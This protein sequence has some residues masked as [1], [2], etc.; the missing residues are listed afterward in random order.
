MLGPA[1]S[2]ELCVSNWTDSLRLADLLCRLNGQHTVLLLDDKEESSVMFFLTQQVI[3]PS[4]LLWRLP[5][6]RAE[7]HLSVGVCG[8]GY[9][10]ER[11][12]WEWG[13]CRTQHVISIHQ[14]LLLR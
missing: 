1:G 11:G 5:Q 9:E 4:G 10:R 6:M 8:G 3:C 12:H 13:K 14:H 7:R 2:Q